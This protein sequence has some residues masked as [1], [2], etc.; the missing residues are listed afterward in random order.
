M[1]AA[2]QKQKASV[3]T[4]KPFFDLRG[5]VHSEAQR[6]KKGHGPA[7]RLVRFNS[8]TALDTIQKQLAETYL[9]PLAEC[10]I[11]KPAW[12]DS[13]TIDTSLHQNGK[14]IAYQA[15]KPTLQ[16][17]KLIVTLN[18][19][20]E[21][22][23]IEV[24]NKLAQQVATHQDTMIFQRQKIFQLVSHQQAVGGSKNDLDVR[25]HW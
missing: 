9:Q 7:T 10:D 11:N 5:W 21:V 23:Y 8:Q 14:T 12:F 17:Q 6:W 15:T 16:T 20:Q 18:E 3:E 19:L 25:F 2:C 13:Y 1:V 24:H 4:P 22:E